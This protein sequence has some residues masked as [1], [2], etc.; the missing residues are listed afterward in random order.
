M[1]WHQVGAWPSATTI[2]TRNGP[3]DFTVTH[4]SYH[5]PNISHYGHWTSNFH[6]KWGGRQ[7]IGFF[8]IDWFVFSWWQHHMINILG[9]TSN[10]SWHRGLYHSNYWRLSSDC[11]I[12]NGGIEGCQSDSFISNRYLEGCQSDILSLKAV[13]IITGDMEGCHS[14]S[15]QCF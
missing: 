6:E 14:D 13:R 7:H 10:I 4:E 1:S 15:L 2:L 9:V 8:V 3:Q 12:I 5:V 11:F